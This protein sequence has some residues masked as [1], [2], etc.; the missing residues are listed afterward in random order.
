MSV[1]SPK[2]AIPLDQLW[3]VIPVRARDKRPAIGEWRKYQQARAKRETVVQ[4]AANDT[5]NAGIVTGAVSG[6]IVLDLDNAEAIAEAAKRG[7][8]E[9]VTVQTGK[10]RHVYFR[11]T[12][13]QVPNRAGL[14]PG[15]DL[16]GDGGYVVAPG[17]IHPSGAVYQWLASPETM[18]LAPPPAWLLALIDRA[19]PQPALQ[20]APEPRT[21]PITA[22]AGRYSPYGLSALQGECA[23]IRTAHNG[24]QEHTLNSAGLNRCAGGG[25]RTGSRGGAARTDRGG[26]G[27]AEPPGGPMGRGP[28]R[29]QD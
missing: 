9:T 28:D 15:A 14:F 21:G 2:W 26:H 5:L 18:P 22:G 4:W 11:H 13:E 25:R 24:E 23:A 10:G 6:L 29:A 7:L 16:R 20:A 19:D 1:L 8:P 17:S 12:G 27:N 3:S